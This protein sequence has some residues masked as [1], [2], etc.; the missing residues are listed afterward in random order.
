MSSPFSLASKSVLRHACVI[1]HN[2][3]HSSTGTSTAASTP[4]RISNCGPSL[5]QVSSNS[6]K[7]VLHRVQ[8]LYA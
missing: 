5:I 2:R 3:F 1:S 8:A 4:P 6:L 7:R